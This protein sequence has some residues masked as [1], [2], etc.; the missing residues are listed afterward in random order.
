[1]NRRRGKKGRVNLFLNC[2]KIQ[3]KFN[4]NFQCAQCFPRQP[5]ICQ[6]VPTHTEP[7]HWNFSRLSGALIQK[8]GSRGI[9]TEDTLGMWTRS[10]VEHIRTFGSSFL[11]V[12]Q[13]PSACRRLIK[14]IRRLELCSCFC[15]YCSC[16]R[17]CSPF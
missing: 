1:M 17:R 13:H 7:G 4:F 8:V 9:R 2:Y 6:L 11:K 12:S 5:S 14:Q 15:F 3:K 16:S 10:T